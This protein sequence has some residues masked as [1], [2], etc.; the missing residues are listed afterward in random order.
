MLLKPKSLPMRREPMVNFRASLILI[1]FGWLLGP[2]AAVASGQTYLQSTGAPASTTALPVESGF[3]DASTGRLHLSIPLG[4][5]PQRG[6]RTDNV[7]LV[8]D[9][10]IW[11]NANW[12]SSWY[13]TNVST[14]DGSANSWS[15][16]RLVTSGDTG[17]VTFD[18]NDSGYCWRDDSDQFADFSN[19]VWFAPDGTHTLVRPQYANAWKAIAQATTIQQRRVLPPMAP[20]II[21]PLLIIL[22]PKCGLRT[23]QLYTTVH[24]TLF[25]IRCR[26][27]PTA[28]TT[29]RE[30]ARL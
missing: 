11:T 15:G 8:Y 3:I 14:S 1:A 16:W 13:P 24:T 4:S 18:E 20:A 9:S 25:R 6:G 19:F 22:L 10:N 23:A 5:F 2:N 27:T 28:T 7:A 21:C 29:T 30:A 12:S 26:K 17:Y